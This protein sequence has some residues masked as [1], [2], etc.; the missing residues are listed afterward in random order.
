MGKHLSIITEALNQFCDLPDHFFLTC[1][2]LMSNPPSGDIDQST[3]ISLCHQFWGK[4]QLYTIFCI[5]TESFFYIPY[6]LF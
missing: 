1:R 6:N 2:L 3:G 4:H 5:V